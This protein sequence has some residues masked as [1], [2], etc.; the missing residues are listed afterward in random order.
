MKALK[1]TDNIITALDI[2]AYKI[3]GAIFQTNFDTQNYQQSQK[4]MRCLSA[5]IQ[6]TKGFSNGSIVHFDDFE[7][8]I[9][10][11]LHLLEQESKH[12]VRDVYVSL[13]GSVFQSHFLTKNISLMG[14][15]VTQDT[16]R[17][18]IHDAHHSNKTHEII[19]ITPIQFDLDD[20]KNIEDPKKMVG[21]HLTAYLHIMSVSRTFLNNLKTLFARYDLNVINFLASPVATL[22]S[23]DH[24]EN[25]II[26]DFGHE[27]TNLILYKN[28]VLIF[29]EAI[30]LGGYILTKEIATALKITTENAERLKNYNGY[31]SSAEIELAANGDIFVKNDC[32]E[33]I[34]FYMQ[35]LVM[36]IKKRLEQF[37]HSYL[38][39]IAITG[40]G[41]ELKGLSTYI[42]DILRE[43]IT[44][45][46]AKEGIKSPNF[47]SCWGAVCYGYYNTCDINK[48][49]KFSHSKGLWQKVKNWFNEDL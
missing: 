12:T 44:T 6:K 46:S 25:G 39:N 32:N 11:T 26:I 37:D 38:K 15:S 20:V 8:S 41:S 28:G 29:H 34:R 48:M 43:K 35:N 27:T 14:A 9:L 5:H 36:H 42:E 16:I 2:G 47:T 24:T 49:Q 7:A 30:A 17:K 10:N 22:L 33:I 4:T 31:I 40:G 13:P 1:K 45:L 23:F 3:S 21:N 19:H 18:L